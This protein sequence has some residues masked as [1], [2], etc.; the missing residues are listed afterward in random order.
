MKIFKNYKNLY[1]VELHNRKIYEER[2]KE[3]YDENIKLQEL[4]AQL[5][6]ELEDLGG[7]YIQ[8][9]ECSEAL[10]KERKKLRSMITKLGGN[11]KDGK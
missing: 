8:E 7:F 1:N 6:I 5:K 10:R 3:L 9:K 2:Y 11:W 4:V